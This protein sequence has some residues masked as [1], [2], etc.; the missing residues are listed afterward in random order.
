MVIGFACNLDN[1]IL[2]FPGQSRVNWNINNNHGGVLFQEI[3]TI[4]FLRLTGKLGLAWY[5]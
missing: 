3:E 2:R 1:N 5:V 4:I